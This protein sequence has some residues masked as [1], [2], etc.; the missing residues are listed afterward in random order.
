MKFIVGNLISFLVLS[1]LVGIL[2]D[3][4]ISEMDEKVGVSFEAKKGRS[5]SNVA[6]GIPVCLHHSVKAGEQHI[7]PNIKLATFIEQWFL[8][9]LLKY[10]GARIAITA[11]LLAF[12]P[13]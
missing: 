13:Q 9:V 10:E 8:D 11:L 5:S 7:V 6:L 12:Q 1:V 4:V 2:L 3:C